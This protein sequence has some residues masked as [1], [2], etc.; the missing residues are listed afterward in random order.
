M[1]PRSKL[2][3]K[4]G[5][6]LPTISEGTEET[7]RDL[8]EAN[9]QR[10]VEHVSSDDYL[11]SICHLAHPTFPTGGAPPSARHLDGVHQKMRT[12][13]LSETKS[14]TFNHRQKSVQQIERDE[15]LGSSDPLEYLYGHHSKLSTCHS[16]SRAYPLDGRPCESEREKQARS[17]AHSIP[18]T[19]SPGLPRQRKSSC[20]EIHANTAT[21]V[22][23][24]STERNRAAPIAEEGIVSDSKADGE[25]VTPNKRHSMVSQWISDCRSAWNE[26]R[27]R[28]CMLPAITEI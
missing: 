21:T 5:L 20:P 9:V 6:Q 14:L 16:R 7:L 18:H 15:V 2:L 17:R 24:V 27:I 13:R 25:G 12:S 28:A 11:L 19:A 26:G 3:S 8:N 1:R 23:S 10:G 22:P 4:G